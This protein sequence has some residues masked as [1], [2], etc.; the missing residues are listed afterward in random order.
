MHTNFNW[1][2]VEIA[3]NEKINRR[4]QVS[5]IIN[6]DDEMKNIAGQVLKHNSKNCINLCPFNHLLRFERQMRPSSK[7]TQK[8]QKQATLKN[9]IC[10]LKKTGLTSKKQLL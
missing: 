2:A 8:Y 5:R 1:K 4:S 9:Q 10:F 7:T 3:Q 6:G